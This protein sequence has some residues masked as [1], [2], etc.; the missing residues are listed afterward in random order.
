M[1]SQPISVL[2]SVQTPGVHQLQG[3][4]TLFEILSVA[5]GLRPDAGN[6]IKISRRMAWGRIPSGERGR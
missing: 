3:Q 2:G 1:R 5:G 6:T 4:K